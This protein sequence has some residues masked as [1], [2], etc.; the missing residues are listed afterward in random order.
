VQHAGF[1][2]PYR[3]LSSSSSSS[4]SSSTFLTENVPILEHKAE[5]IPNFRKV[6]MWTFTVWV[7]FSYSIKL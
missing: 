6:H 4:S 5:A 1:H 3:Q 2:Y 7:Q